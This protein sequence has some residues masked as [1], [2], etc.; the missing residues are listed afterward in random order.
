MN[1]ELE[2]MWE[3]AVVAYL[4]VLSWYSPGGIEG[5]HKNIYVPR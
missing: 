4:I 3:E 2:R 1:D 5:S